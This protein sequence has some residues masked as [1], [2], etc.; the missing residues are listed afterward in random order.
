[1]GATDK[2]RIL[3]DARDLFGG[4][5]LAQELRVSEAVLDAWICGDATMPEGELLRLSQAL[6]RLATAKR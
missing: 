5:V 6:I 4:K 1:M 2:Q 3:K